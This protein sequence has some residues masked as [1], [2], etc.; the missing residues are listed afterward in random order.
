MEIGF[1]PVFVCIILNMENIIKIK[2]LTK[3][4]QVPEKQSFW[5]SVFFAKNIPLVAV[6][7]INFSIK[8]GESV[9]LL[10]P[11]GAGKTTT[12]KMLTGL[13]FPTSGDIK[14]LGFT[15]TDRKRE[16]LK[17][18]ALV[19]GNKSG[20]SWDLSARQSFNL[21]KTIYQISDK[22][23]EKRLIE[24]TDLL[25]AQKQLDTPI[26]KLS[27]G[28]RLKMELIGAILHRPKLLFLDEPTIGLDVVSK[29]RVR[30]FLRYLHEKEKTTIILTS[31]EMADIEMVSDRVMVINQGKIVFDDSLV[32]LL[33]KY[34]D[35]K[36]LTVTFHKPVSSVKLKKLGQVISSKELSHTLEIPKVNQGKVM[37]YLTVNFEV[38]D[39]DVKSIPLDE[40]IEDLFT[41]TK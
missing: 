14:V 29:R 5:K 13:L 10:G 4:Y 11:N 32:K 35:K 20:L 30:N 26:R 38:D 37:A 39:I 2:S 9:A 34:Q 40:I 31:H 16:Y 17:Q 12:L 6:D 7:D 27:L 28:Q 25:D 8:E 1:A 21:F 23:F 19:M 15:P 36:Y 24:L 3:V 18:I 22:D 41:K 33:H